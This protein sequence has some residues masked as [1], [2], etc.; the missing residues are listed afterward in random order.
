MGLTDDCTVPDDVEK[1]PDGT[2]VKY[3]GNSDSAPCL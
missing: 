2:D 1:G 3:V